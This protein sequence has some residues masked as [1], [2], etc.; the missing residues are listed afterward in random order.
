MIVDT[1]AWLPCCCF[2]TFAFFAKILFS[3]FFFFLFFLLCTACLCTLCKYSLCTWT[4]S[5]HTICICYRKQRR[6]QYK[7]HRS[8]S[9]L[10]SYHQYQYPDINLGLTLDVTTSDSCLLRY[11]QVTKQWNCYI[12]CYIYR[13]NQLHLITNRGVEKG[14]KLKLPKRA[15]HWQRHENGLL[16]EYA[17][18][19]EYQAGGQNIR[20]AER[21]KDIRGF[22]LET[23]MDYKSAPNQRLDWKTE[24]TPKGN[25]RDFTIVYRIWYD[26]SYVFSN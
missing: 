10:D 4:M 19:A 22:K 18:V 15:A 7:I 9:D 8:Q 1:N 11:A 6:P 24:A 12:S 20:I 17:Y 14:D 25:R 3:F 2:V 13:P 23:G 16:Y 26:V 5:L 21:F